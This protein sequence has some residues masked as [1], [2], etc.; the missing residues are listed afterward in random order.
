MRARQMETLRPVR[1]QFRQRIPSAPCR[2]VLYLFLCVE[3][4][5]GDVFWVSAGGGGGGDLSDLSDADDPEDH[6]YGDTEESDEDADVTGQ[7]VT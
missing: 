7:E 2:T 6:D 3:C 4:R 1:L 5:G